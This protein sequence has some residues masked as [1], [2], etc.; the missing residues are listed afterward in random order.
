MSI[1]AKR[2]PYADHIVVLNAE[3]RIAEQGN[4]HVL[5]ATGGYV[6]SFNLPRPDW[7][8]C[9]EESTLKTVP[10]PTADQNTIQTSED[11]EAEANRQ[12]GDFSIYRYYL[13]SVGWLPIMIFVVCISSFI[14]CISFPS[15]Y[16]PAGQRMPMLTAAERHLVEVVG[17]IQRAVSIRANELLSRDICY[18]RR[19]CT[20][21]PD[22]Q[23][24]VSVAA[25]SK[26]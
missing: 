12:T 3:G 21:L 9:V 24:L 7:D 19:A 10:K 5:S 20:D 22:H 14:F 2:L 13:G 23:L 15:E 17:C 26:T 4:F 18:A 11:L 6:S 16:N 1:T 25:Y 8:Y